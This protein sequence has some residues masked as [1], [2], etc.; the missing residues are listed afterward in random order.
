MPTDVDLKCTVSLDGSILRSTLHH[1]G[2]PV[3]SRIKGCIA[4]TNT[5]NLF[6]FS[7]VSLTD[8]ETIASP[9]QNLSVLGSIELCV[10]RVEL[11]KSAVQSVTKPMGVIESAIHERSKK[12]SMHRVTLQG[13]EEFKTPCT[14]YNSK[15]LE[16]VP[17][18]RFIFKYRPKEF[19][20]AQGMVPEVNTDDGASNAETRSKS[21]TPA[22]TNKRRR[23]DQAAE[24][25]N[26]DEEAERRAQEILRMRKQMQ[27]LQANLNRL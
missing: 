25:E 13:T 8:D 11:T 17:H 18:A 6:A 24:G 22:P 12:M 23:R 19:L 26:G 27:E 2:H 14:F 20:R 10:Y 5:L 3:D 21:N 16:N 9:D 4:G 15:L 1:A 7:Q